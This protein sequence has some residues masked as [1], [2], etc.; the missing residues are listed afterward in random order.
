MTRYRA[1]ARAA[2]AQIEVKRPRF[3][4]TVERVETEDAARAVIE[5]VRREHWDARHHC[6]AFIVGP[7]ARLERSND[8]GEPAGM[9]GAPILETMSGHGLSDIVVVVT[10][11]FGG[12]LL[13]AGGLV[14][15]YSAVAQEALDIAGVRERMLVREYALQL[16]HAD[17]GRVERELRS[18]GVQVLDT[19]WGAGAELVLGVPA[20]GTG[21]FVALIAEVTGGASTPEPH[22]E[23]WLDVA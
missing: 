3:L 21:E 20:D 13:G 12:T 2:S 10:R 19:M 4:A 1:P 15:A 14:R 9:A 22:G 11:W 6:S 5:R 8:D 23:R 17:A 16:D 18:R 7:D